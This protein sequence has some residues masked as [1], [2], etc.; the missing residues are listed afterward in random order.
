M[1]KIIALLPILALSNGAQADTAFGSIN[2]FDTVNDTGSTCY[3]F[4]I[5]VD[6][7]LSREIGYTYNFNHYG[8]PKISDDPNRVPGH[9]TV[10]ITY[11]T[12]NPS[13]TT[14]GFTNPVV[15]PIVPT[16]GHQ[17]TNPSVNAGCEHFGA[18]IYSSTY[19]AVKYRWLDAAGNTC[20]DPKGNVHVSTPVWNYQPPVLVKPPVIQPNPVVNQPAIIVPG[21]VAFAAQ[22]QA[23]I[24]APPL[25]VAPAKLFGDPSWV[26]VIRTTS[27]KN[28]PMVL[29]DLVNEPDAN[30]K[31]KWANGET[32]ETET[33]W[34]LL[35]T[36]PGVVKN[37]AKV[38]QPA[39]KNDDMGDG[40]EVVTRRYEYYAYAAGDDTIDGDNGE[41]M[42]D[43]VDPTL[44][45]AN[46]QYLHGAS[47]LTSVDVAEAGGGSHTV[48][49]T[50]RV[51]V[52]DFLGAQMGG[53]NAIVPFSTI[54][55]IQSGIVG[56]AF[57][58][59]KVLVGGNSPFSTSISGSVPNGLGIDSV[60]GILNGTP[61]R[62]GSFH[63]TVDAYDTNQATGQ[64]IP[65]AQGKG[66]GSHVNRA[67]TLNVT[68]RGDTNTDYEID[69]IDLQAIQAKYGHPAA[70]AND[71][72]D[73][74]GDMKINLLDYRKAASLC[75]KPRC[76]H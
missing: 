69:S 29:D 74:N 73:V 39:V 65:D 18:G 14:S 34:S 47:N 1:K 20:A 27:H 19:T 35:Q 13:G 2:N 37:P 4:E 44:D 59:R 51:L 25:P 50:A 61:T 46:P 3:G 38:A 66:A 60:T 41:A 32:S 5:E 68:G 53:F 8:T 26:K 76:A 54:P 10:L 75:T 56:E 15:G 63:F 12:A 40:T 6:D 33:E 43:E 21:Q 22:V 36:Q 31:P 52:G 16:L 48:D 49:C 55:D 24:P 17:C 42:C 71:P 57:P 64:T 70:D 7:A 30:G 58:D 45:P 72:A 62:V 9:N 11:K 23:V 67:Y 28:N